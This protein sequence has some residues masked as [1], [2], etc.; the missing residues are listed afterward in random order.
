MH[1]HALTLVV[2]IIAASP[3]R[4]PIAIIRPGQGP[5]IAFSIEPIALG[6]RLSAHRFGSWHESVPVRVV[7][8]QPSS[9]EFPIYSDA[10]GQG[11]E[12]EVTSSLPIRGGAL[13]LCLRRELSLSPVGENDA[14][15][16]QDGETVG[17]VHVEWASE[18]VNVE[19]TIAGKI[20]RV[21]F[22]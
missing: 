9:N 5:A 8:S 6:A 10:Y 3:A 7:R 1:A 19:V 21:Y 22:Y 14:I 11:W 13:W 15:I 16:K 18:G 4:E 2:A 20:S 17:S 12:H